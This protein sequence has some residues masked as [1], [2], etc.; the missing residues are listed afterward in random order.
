MEFHVTWDRAFVD[1]FAININVTG[2]GTYKI[3]HTVPDP[4]SSNSFSFTGTFYASGTFSS[5]TAASGTT[6]L[7]NFSIP[8]CGLFSGGPYAWSAGW[9][10]GP[11]M[12]VEAV[13]AAE[14]KLVESADAGNAFEVT[15]IP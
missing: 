6:G 14:T 9:V 4:I 2:C 15:R 12:S 7:T 13:E 8:G 1:D 10:S 11:S 5:Q 3:T